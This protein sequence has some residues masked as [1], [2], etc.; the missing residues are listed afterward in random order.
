MINAIRAHIVEFGTVASVGRKGVELD[1]ATMGYWDM[2][3]AAFGFE[4][5]LD[6]CD[7]LLLPAFFSAI[8]TACF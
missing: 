8:A 3:L 5:H 6:R 1:R 7:F 2:F 4:H